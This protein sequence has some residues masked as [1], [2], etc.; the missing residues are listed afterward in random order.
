MR[1]LAFVLL[2]LSSLSPSLHADSAVDCEEVVRKAVEAMKSRNAAALWLLFDPAMPGFKQLRADSGALLAVANVASSVNFVKN[3]GDDA[4]RTLQLDWQME[5]DQQMRATGV[6]NRRLAVTLALK[7]EAGAWRIVKMSPAEVF[8]PTHVEQAWDQV[9]AAAAAL[10][11]PPDDSPVNPTLFLG[12]FDSKMPG[13][14]KLRENVAA[15]AGRGAIESSVD[16]VWSQGDDRA[17]NM[18]VDWVLQVINPATEIYILRKH[19]HVKLRMEWRGKR[20]SVIA[21]AP[22]G[23][24]A[25]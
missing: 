16:L 18:E 13:F 17:R 12:L 7:H 19:E 25:P 2:S 10:T 22:P 11:S 3:Q 15:L 23:F 5:I 24:F 8:A 9:A 4:A 1:F 21:I 6:T 14:E 20:W